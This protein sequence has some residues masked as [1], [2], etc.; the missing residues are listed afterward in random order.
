MDK[1]EVELSE[2][3]LRLLLVAIGTER[4]RLEAIEKSS[5]DEDEVADAGNDLGVYL[6]I[7]AELRR[8]LDEPGRRR[9]HDE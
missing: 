9:R 7:E 6:A 3:A 5:K 8:A 4:A 2:K 1:I